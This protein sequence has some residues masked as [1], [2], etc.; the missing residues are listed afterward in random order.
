MVWH[1]ANFEHYSS[2]WRDIAFESTKDQEDWRRDSDGIIRIDGML[3]NDVDAGVMNV[4][5]HLKTYVKE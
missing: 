1:E 3:K 2:N 5:E 4:S